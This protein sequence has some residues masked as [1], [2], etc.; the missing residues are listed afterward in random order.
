MEQVGRNRTDAIDGF[1]RHASHLIHDRDPLYTLA[2][3]P[4]GGCTAP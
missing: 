1:L 4:L 2:D 3:E